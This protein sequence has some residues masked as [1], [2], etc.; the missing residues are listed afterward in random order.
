M[1][2]LGALIVTA[3]NQVNPLAGKQNPLPPVESLSGVDQHLWV[4]VGP[5]EASL[6]VSVVEPAPQAEARGPGEEA[7]ELEEARLLVSLSEIN[8]ALEPAESIPSNLE[9]AQK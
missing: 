5:P 9:V 4:D 2:P 1:A 8:A 3:P 6:S 7:P